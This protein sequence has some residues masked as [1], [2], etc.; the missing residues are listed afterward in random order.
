MYD[1]L[2]KAHSLIQTVDS[3]QEEAEGGHCIIPTAKQQQQN[4]NDE[5]IL[6]GA[7]DILHH[8][9]TTKK[10]DGEYYSSNEMTLA[11]EEQCVYPMLYNAICWMTDSK[12]YADVE[13][14]K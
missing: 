12:L 11:A 8:I 3:L 6:H 4:T 2:S 9:L 5:S 14:P 10:L 13:I 1:A 7:I